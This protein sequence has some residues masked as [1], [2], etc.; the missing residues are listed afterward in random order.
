M[1][2]VRSRIWRGCLWIFGLLLL[3]IMAGGG[4]LLLQARPN[5]GR[6][7]AQRSP[8]AGA[9]TGPEQSERG[10]FTSQAVRVRAKD[11]RAVDLRVLRPQH[12]DGPLPLVVILGGHRTGRDAVDLLG[13]PGPFVVAAL[14]YPYDGP[15]RPRGLQQS[16]ATIPAARRAL[17]ATPPAALLAIDWLTAQPW[18][19][20]KR[21]EVVGV[22]F[23]VPF[24]TVVGALEP[25]VGRVW[26]IHGG[27]GNREWIEHNLRPRIGNAWL[28]FACG[29]LVYLLAHG[30]TL[31]VEH[32]VPLI[33]P[34][35]VIIIG[36]RNDQRLPPELVERLHASAGTPKEL[37][38]MK[39]GHID[40]RPDA[41][42]Q[43]LEIVRS[44]M[45]EKDG[46]EDGARP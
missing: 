32:W 40:R 44:R 25:R 11:G 37:I 1:N 3:P 43:L 8:V 28:R 2:A 42:Q 26:L 36:A 12:A 39:G 31:E 18:V 7:A 15:E 33:A 29:W 27:A 10:G 21:V 6:F 38:W 23:G 41:V 45:T 9:E 30:P 17:L 5:Y 34:R 22:S 13:A 16:L 19:D 14:D 35:P 20:A 24:A 46:P 4:W